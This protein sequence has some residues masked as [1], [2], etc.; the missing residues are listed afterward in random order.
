MINLDRGPNIYIQEISSGVHT[1]RSV[2]TSIT[3][4]IGWAPKGPTDKA[5]LVQSWTEYVNKFGDVSPLTDVWMGYAVNLFFANGGSQA[6]IVRVVDKPTAKSASLATPLGGLMIAA[7][8]EGN[9]GN[10]Y[11]VTVPSS[12]NN[13]FTLNIVQLPTANQAMAV[14]ESY[15]NLSMDPTDSRYAVT[16]INQESDWVMAS[17]ANPPSTQAPAQNTNP[18]AFQGGVDGNV[19]D[20]SGVATALGGNSIAT[21]IPNLDTVPLFNLMCVPGLYD[22]AMLGF[23]QTYCQSRRAFL[24][25]DC[26]P[27]MNI[28]AVGNTPPNIANGDT[29]TYG[30][31]YFPWLKV[32][33]PASPGHWKSTPPCGIVAGIYARTDGTRGVWKAPAGIEAGVNGGAVDVS[34][35]MT[36]LQNGTVNSAG[37]NCIRQFP[38]YGIV[39]WG[40][41]TLAGNDDLGSEWKYIPVRRTALFIEESL[42]HGLKWVVF[43]PNAEPLWAQIRL[44]VG[45]FMHDLFRQGAFEGQKPADAYF[46][47]CDG[48]TTTQNDINLGIVNILVGFAPL[49][50]AEFVV[51][52]IQQMAG[53]IQT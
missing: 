41:R 14:V 18:V 47:K 6:L 3:A 11:G 22:P 39:L 15:R 20:P 8:G 7:N 40:A 37:V 30:A 23:F 24:I 46:V 4:F 13:R 16:V 53:Q 50:P 43:E 9:W 21:T 19:L 32:M 29:A 5:M 33:D 28:D 44:N 38:T 17:V 36:D 49:E 25:A 26:D 1:I 52:Q 2:A 48:E 51:I 35:P 42:S 45:A 27:G 12:K 34:I 10:S 31:I